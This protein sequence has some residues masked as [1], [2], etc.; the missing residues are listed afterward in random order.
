MVD[1][2]KSAGIEVTHKAVKE[3]SVF[4]QD[5]KPLFKGLIVFVSD[6]W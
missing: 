4:N 2:V 1:G 6:K 3:W 5:F